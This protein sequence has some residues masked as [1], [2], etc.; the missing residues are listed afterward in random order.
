MQTNLTA[1]A[2]AAA[3]VGM[4]PSTYA[5]SGF[6]AAATYLPPYCN[7]QMPVM[8]QNTNA[9]NVGGIALTAAEATAAGMMPLPNAASGFGAAATYLPPYCNTQL[10]VMMQ[11]TNASNVGGIAM[12]AAEAT[13]AGMMSHDAVNKTT[14]SALS[15]L[16]LQDALAS[17]D[18]SAYSPY[19]RSLHQRGRN[20]LKKSSY[21][22]RNHGIRDHSKSNSNSSSNSSSSSSYNNT[23]SNSNSSSNPLNNRVQHSP[24]MTQPSSDTLPLYCCPLKFFREDDSNIS[25]EAQIISTF[26]SRLGSHRWALTMRQ[27]LILVNGLNDYVES[28]TDTSLELIINTEDTIECLIS[29]RSEKFIYCKMPSKKDL[30]AILFFK[31]IINGKSKECWR[32]EGLNVFGQR[33][34][35]HEQAW[36]KY[37][38]SIGNINSL[39][40]DISKWYV[41][42]SGD[43]EKFQ[44]CI[45]FINEESKT[46][47]RIRKNSLAYRNKQIRVQAD[48]VTS[49]Q[50]LSMS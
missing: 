41:E 40:S 6:G 5:A 27:G 22:K 11:N 35:I 25:L 31:M 26:G 34:F 1:A 20:K 43:K 47:I 50:K 30:R 7:T 44:K 10:P 13:A 28:N 16:P 8:M 38:D 4:M 29:E 45:A 36:K 12:T 19:K 3:T 24:M 33:T 18:T 2:V 23:N 42:Q 32:S 37:Q 15:S 49:G 39:E 46:K 48:R 21:H 17:N 9:S 14:H